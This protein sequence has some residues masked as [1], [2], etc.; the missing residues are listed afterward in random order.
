MYAI[1][2]VLETSQSRC[3]SLYVT[4]TQLTQDTSDSFTGAKTTRLHSHQLRYSTS[5]IALELIQHC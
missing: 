2:F 3:V 5:A 4:A 1:D